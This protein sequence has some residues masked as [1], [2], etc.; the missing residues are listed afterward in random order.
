MKK[1]VIEITQN[2]TVN[3]VNFYIAMSKKINHE[4]KKDKSWRKVNLLITTHRKTNMYIVSCHL[5][6]T[7]LISYLW[8]KVNNTFILKT[9]QSMS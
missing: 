1:L 3:E 7:I 2:I 5:Q 6:R 4:K 9:P 8:D